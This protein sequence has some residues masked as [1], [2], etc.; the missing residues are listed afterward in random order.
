MTPPAKL[1]GKEFEG[2]LIESANRHKGILKLGRYGTQSRYDKATRQLVPM[3]SNPDLDG[4]LSPYGRHVISEAKVTS[5]KSLY[6]ANR[7]K[8]DKADKQL[9]F[10]LEH[11][12]LGAICFYAIHFNK[13]IGVTFVSEAES[14]AMPV[15]PLIPFWKK[16]A[17]GE[18]TLLNPET[19]PLHGGI[20]IDWVVPN[21]CR[22]IRP[23]ILEAIYAVS[24]F[25]KPFQS[26][27][28]E[29]DRDE[30]LPNLP[31]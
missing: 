15:H 7:I 5:S 21:R 2:E 8:D 1:K 22:R 24:D 6:L 14:W 25:L 17:S 30:S 13:R 4:S 18:E 9:S 31:F 12:E 16:F 23:A 3:K 28:S 11:S 26:A 20:K 19:L 27:L 10:M 29:E